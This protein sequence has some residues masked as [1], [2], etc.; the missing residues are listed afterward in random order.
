MSFDFIALQHMWRRKFCK[1]NQYTG[2]P[3]GY[4]C[5]LC[6]TNDHRED[7]YSVFESLIDLLKHEWRITIDI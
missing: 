2:E 7:N 6:S 5:Q 3:R 1:Q 4:Q